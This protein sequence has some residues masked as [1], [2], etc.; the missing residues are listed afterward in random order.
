MRCNPVSIHGVL[1]ERGRCV[2][3]MSTQRVQHRRDQQHDN[4]EDRANPA[5]LGEML[6]RRHHKAMLNARNDRPG[7]T[8]R[9]ATVERPDRLRG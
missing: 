3:G 5:N 1:G 7:T 8:K 2:T 6:F 9:R 4:T